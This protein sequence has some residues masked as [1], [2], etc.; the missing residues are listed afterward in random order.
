MT[1]RVADWPA[2]LVTRIPELVRSE[3][4]L[5]AQARNLS[6]QDVIRAILCAHARLKCP[7]AS[8][9]YEPLRDSGVSDTIHLRMQKKLKRALEREAAR[10]NRP[11][12]SVIIDALEAHYG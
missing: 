8:Y 9:G 2:Y 11:L 3:L 1:D 7:Q 12:R 10:T 4:S 5:E 6:V